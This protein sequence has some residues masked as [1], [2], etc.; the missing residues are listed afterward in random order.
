M[1]IFQVHLNSAQLQIYPRLIQLQ[2]ELRELREAELDFR[3][4]IANGKVVLNLQDE[5]KFGYNYDG[6]LHYSYW[7]SLSYFHLHLITLIDLFKKM[8]QIF[9]LI[10]K[11]MRHNK[12]KYDLSPAL[13]LTVSK[14]LGVSI[15]EVCFLVSFVDAI[16]SNTIFLGIYWFINS[17]YFP[18]IYDKAITLPRTFPEKWI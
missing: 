3:S 16:T 9:G 5:N 8:C 17:N 13:M 12:Q 7:V 11:L 18:I 14:F 15:S 6:G 1:I 10:M 2:H 4:G